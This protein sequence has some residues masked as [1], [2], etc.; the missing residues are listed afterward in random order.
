MGNIKLLLLRG[1]KA[2]ALTETEKISNIIYINIEETYCIINI[3][4]VH[5]YPEVLFNF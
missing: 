4:C 3:C 5:L 2:F 1:M